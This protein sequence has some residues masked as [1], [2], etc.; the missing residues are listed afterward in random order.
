MYDRVTSAKSEFFDFFNPLQGKI[1]GAAQQ[2]LDYIG[3]VDPAQYNVGVVNN[4]GQTWGAEHVGEMWWDISTVRFIDPNQDSIVYASRR[5]G[6]VFPGSRVDVYQWVQSS[7]PPANYTG[8]GTPLNTLSYVVN[9]RLNREGTFLTEYYFWVRNVVE[10]YTQQGK[11]LSSVVVA[12]YIANP[13]ASG[14]AYIAPINASTIAIYNGLQYVEAFDTIISIE[15]D[16][17]YNNANQQGQCGHNFKVQQCHATYSTHAFHTF[18]TG[19][20]QHNGYKNDGVDEELD[21]VYEIF[22]QGLHF[23]SNIGAKVTQ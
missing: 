16:Q 8:T 17:T 6:Q 11:S 10:T 7:T 14:I 23:N 1:L 4:I 18:H 20:T 22:A 15:F 13:K 21:D 19:N 9:T 2:N 3:A 5:W 12:S